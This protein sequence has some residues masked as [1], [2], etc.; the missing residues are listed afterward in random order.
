M[1]RKNLN[2]VASMGHSA[3]GANATLACQLDG[4]FRAC[5]SLDGAMPPVAAF[6]ENSEGKWFTQPVLLLE[7]DHNGRW[8][9][10][11]PTQN[12][13]F[14]KKKED[15]LNRCPAGS[16][17]V[18]LKSP[19]LVHGSFSDYPLFAAMGKPP[20]PKTLFII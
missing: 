18:V 9:G 17:D 19:G 11:N 3:G 15:Q 5:L 20:K 7:V 12:D 4:R 14:L 1:A 8:V 16:Y 2:R 10:F 6:P 13:A